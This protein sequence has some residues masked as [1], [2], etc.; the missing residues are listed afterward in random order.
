MHFRTILTLISLLGA[1]CGLPAQAQTFAPA[2]SASD[3]VILE[4]REAFNKGQSTRLTELLPRTQGHVL[5]PWAAYWE[6]RVRLETAAPEEVER[7]L[8]RYA[9]TYLEDRLRN[10]WLLLLGKNRDWTRFVIEASKFR[11]QDDREVRCYV[12]AMEQ[13]LARVDMSREAQA[14]CFFAGANSIFFGDRLLTTGNAAA[15]EDL[16]LLRELGVSPL[17]PFAEDA[18][19][20]ACLKEERR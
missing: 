11:M 20:H 16:A 3:A 13:I 8:N 6:L 5:A 2:L 17:A 18:Q 1:L 4:M 9:G 12:L 15:E 10:D 19:P 14:L 7:F